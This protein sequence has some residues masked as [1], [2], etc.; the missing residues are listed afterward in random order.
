VLILKSR[1]HQ[2]KPKNC[3]R[4]H[5]N[6]ILSKK[7]RTKTFSALILSAYWQVPPAWQRHLKFTSEQHFRSE[8]PPNPVFLNHPVLPKCPLFPA[9][10]S[11]GNINSWGR[12]PLLQ[13]THCLKSV[14]LYFQLFSYCS[15][16]SFHRQKLAVPRNVVTIQCTVVLFG[17]SLS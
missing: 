3:R 12:N 7:P 15:M 2:M 16:N 14:R 1:D 4:Y 17:T 5:W 10:K 11:N 6:Q 13:Q 9:T 8:K